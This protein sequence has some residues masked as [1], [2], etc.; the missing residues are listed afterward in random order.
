[1][2]TIVI[3]IG[4]SAIVSKNADASFLKKFASLIRKL[5]KQYMIYMIVGGGR[6]ARTYIEKGRELDLDENTLDQLGIEI[7]RVNAQ[8]LTSIIGV[9]NKK[10]PLTTDEAKK[11]DKPIVIMGG[12]VPGHSTDLVGAELAEKT[13]A[14]KFII[15]TNVDGIYDKDPNKYRDAKKLNKVTINELIKKYGIDWSTAGSNVVVDGPALEIIKKAKITTF[16]LNGGRLNQL[17]RAINN[18]SFDGTIIV[19]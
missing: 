9:S 11:I 16:V 1:M 6:T 7:T 14:D 19:P 8:L 18:K 17:E 3:S 15:A 4:G 10:I 5:S 13:D 2:E 12:T